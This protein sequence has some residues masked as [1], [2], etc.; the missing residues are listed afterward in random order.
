[1]ASLSAPHEQIGAWA[2]DE[3]ASGL[4]GLV[5]LRWLAAAGLLVATGLVAGVWRRSLPVVPLL[6]LGVATLAYNALA[7]WALLRLN[8]SPDRSSAAY[9]R[10]A[11][12][13]IGLDWVLL[14]LVTLFSGGL[15]SPALF[16]VLAHVAIVFCLLPHVMPP[17]WALVTPLL[18]GLAAI[19]ALVGALPAL[20]SARDPLC[21]AGVWLAFT[22]SI[23]LLAHFSLRMAQRLRRREHK[24]LG[25]YESVQATAL[26]LDL[27]EVLNRLAEATARALGCK[28]A[29]IRLLDKSGSLLELAAACGLSE[30]YVDKGPVELTRS[31]IDQEVLSGHTLIVHDAALEPRLQY[32]EKVVAEGIRSILI[33]PLIGKRGP[34]GVLRAYDAEAHRFTDDDAAF[35]SLIAAQGALAIENAQA[36]Q[37]LESLDRSKSQ[38]VRMVTHELRSPIQVAS[39]LLNVLEHGYVGALNEKQADLVDRAFRRLQFLQLLIDD[40]LDLAAGR[41]DVLATAERGPVALCDVMREVRLRFEEQARTKGI[42]LRVG[43]PREGL[44][45]WGN[46][47]ELDRIMNNLVSNA[48]KYTQQGEVRIFAERGEG[49]V[50]IVVSDTGHRHPRGGDAP[51]VRGVL[52]RAERQ[53]HQRDRHRPGPGHRQGPDRA[54]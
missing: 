54:L 12:I 49:V 43:C 3:L 15:E 39:S 10:Q 32:R 41:A 50:R 11:R 23:G 27:S 18:V 19:P 22:V 33:A 9:R 1:M 24:L 36:Y 14:A 13:Q 29:A 40:L 25:L 6:A 51:P 30:A 34:V 48:V 4:S 16:G 20:G 53:G 31:R 44:N 21:L 35:L 47:A 26:T 7:R 52:P 8:I 38:F 42:A 37:L 2:D 45:I 46:R 5:Q 17:L 28:G